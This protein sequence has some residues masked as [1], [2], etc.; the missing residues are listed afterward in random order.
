MMLPE[1]A[2]DHFK[3]NWFNSQHPGLSVQ[4]LFPYS[5]PQGL[6]DAV[7]SSAQSLLFLEYKP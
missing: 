5:N 1:S 6:N 7:S 3:G 4:I 2:L